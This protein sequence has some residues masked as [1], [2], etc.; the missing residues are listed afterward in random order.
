MMNSIDPRITSGDRVTI[1]LEVQVAD[2][3]SDPDGFPEVLIAT[4]GS[5]YH[6]DK[7]VTA[8]L[9]TEW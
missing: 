6:V 3:Y 4:D 1:I 8:Y 2:L 5:E 7:I 9:A